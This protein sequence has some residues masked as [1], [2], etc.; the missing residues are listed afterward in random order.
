MTARTGLDRLTYEKEAVAPFVGAIGWRSMFNATWS[1]GGWVAT[2]WLYLADSI[3]LWAAMLLAGF[4]IQ[5]CYMP[6]HE[7]VH[8]T[9]SGGRA[10]L[11][12]IDRGVGAICGWLMLIS[13][14][15]HRITHLIH[16]THANDEFDPDVLNSKGSPKDLVVRSIIGFIV[17]P[18]GPVI[19]V[20]PA[21]GKLLPAAVAQRLGMSAKLR[22]PEAV[23]AARRVGWTH[24]AFL[25]VGS[26][27]GFGVVVWLL[28][29]VPVWVGR[30]WL[31]GVFG[32]LPH[33]PHGETGRYRDTRI[34]TFPGSGFLIRGHDYHLLHHMF[35]RVPHYHLRKL[36]DEMGDHLVEQGARVEGSA[37]KRVVAPAS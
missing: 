23:A 8:K 26:L 9:L 5:A 18:L 3:P 27:L 30:V 35:P 28:W 20:V 22:G 13:F 32:W 6:V 15:D 29:Y 7:A 33:H 12:W 4:F 24:L 11:S 37:A 10:Q 16:H 36:F 1:V 34:F 31:S 25:V 21:L 14:E 19:S 2:V 17:Y